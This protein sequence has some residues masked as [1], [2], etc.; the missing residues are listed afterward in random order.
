MIY[1]LPASYRRISN[2][3]TLRL[4]AHEW[5]VV[6]GSGHSPEHACLYC[7]TLKLLIS[8]D[9]VL[10][11]ISSNVSVYPTEP[12]ADP[13][14]DW[15]NSLAMISQRIPDDVLVLPAHNSP[16]KGLHARAGEL[17]ESHRRGLARLENLLAEPKRAIEVFGALFGRPITPDLLGMA[18]GEAIAHLNH[19]TRAGRAAREL[20]DAGVWRWRKCAQT[21]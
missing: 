4:G 12:D 2:G 9:Q 11:R 6:V 10:P 5:I 20:D 15:L 1:P 21:D 16:F 17:I 13:L 7:P 14:S 3:D 18:T 19:L 8:G